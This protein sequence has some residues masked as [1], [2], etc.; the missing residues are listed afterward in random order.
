MKKKIILSILLFVQILIVNVLSFFPE[1]V[2]N[3]YSNGL[4]PFIAKCSR[5]F[6]G[7]FGF[8]VG[9]IIYGIVI[10]FIL[11][12]LWKTRKTWRREY[13]SNILSILSF[14]SV[15]YFLFYSLWAVNYHRVPLNE[16]M[17]FEK[18]YT[19]DELLAFTKRLIVKAN[20]MHNLIEPNDSLKVVNPYTVSQ[21]YDKAQNGYDNLSKVYPFFTY[22]TESVKSS[23]ISTPLSYMGF[24]GY[25]NPFTNE[26]QVNYNLPLYNY[27][28]TTCHEMSHQLGYASESE[29]NF[30]GYMA[31]IHNDDLYFKYSGYVFALKY[32]LRNI[33]KID[34]EQAKSLLPLINN[35]ILRNFEES[36]Q[37]NDYYS[38]FIEVI[39]KG[40]Y[41][42]Y[43]KMNHQKDG[44]ETYSKFVGYLVNYYKE[45]DL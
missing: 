23:L 30:I 17:G 10:F 8:S 32:C 36:E 24:G 26:A 12:W 37:F 5:T 40:F 38:S 44:L 19:Q 34:E 3:Y 35:G 7:L 6:F 13:K 33:E 14:F 21:I 29:A 31:S 1:F 20:N 41:D 45:K 28:T 11:R 18:K 42:N 25:L 27:P 16:K 4:Y 22:K 2:E 39:F 9:D 15:F 43:L